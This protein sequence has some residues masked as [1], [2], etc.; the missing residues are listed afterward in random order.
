MRK[1]FQPLN[2]FL[3][4]LWSGLKF[5]G[6]GRNLILQEFPLLLVKIVQSLML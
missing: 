4:R 1:L 3:D 2:W 6:K 5:T